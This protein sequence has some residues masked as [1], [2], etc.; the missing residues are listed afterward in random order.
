MTDDMV[1]LRTLVE[2]TLE[3]RSVAQDWLCRPRS[4]GAGSRK[5]D[6][7]WLRREDPGVWRNGYRDRTWETRAGTVELRIRP[8][9]VR[10][11]TSPASWSR[12]GR[13]RRR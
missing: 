8:S 1:D 13:P 6:R 7:G 4:D 2:K 12:A 11:P 10:A 9:C 5:P 3:S